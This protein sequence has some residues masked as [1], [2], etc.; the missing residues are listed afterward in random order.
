LIN[1]EQD[2]ELCQ[3]ILDA[4][5]RGEVQIWTSSLTLAEVYK[6]K[7]DGPKSLAIEYDQI[8]E[9]YIA[10][11]FVTEVQVDH[12]IAVLS[13]RLCRQHL[14]LRKPNDGIHLAS[15][16]V[17][18]LD[19]FHTFDFGDLLVL[20]GSISRANGSLLKMCKPY[21]I[22]EPQEIEAVRVSPLQLSLENLAPPQLGAA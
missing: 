4:A 1:G 9:S 16:I 14:P 21:L 7:C 19:E 5:I 13:R 18:N 11:D 6:F 22:V 15:A 10:S 20:N 17:N 12:E 3:S 2:H 8:F